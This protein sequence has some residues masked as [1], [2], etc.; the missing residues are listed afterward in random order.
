MF[1]DTTNRQH[2]NVMIVGSVKGVKGTGHTA[3]AEAVRRRYRNAPEGVAP[4]SKEK[5]TRD[6]IML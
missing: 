3:A 1:Q 2:Y 4:G 6:G 5:E